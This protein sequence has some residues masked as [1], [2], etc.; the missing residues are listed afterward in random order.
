MIF[1]EKLLCF[2][3]HV[4][5]YLVYSIFSGGVVVTSL[6]ENMDKKHAFGE[7]TC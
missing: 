1:V 2:V 6:V 4:L 3:S 5:P 7:K